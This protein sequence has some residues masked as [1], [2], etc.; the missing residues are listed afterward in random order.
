MHKILNRAKKNAAFSLEKKYCNN[1]RRGNK[2]G[3]RSYKVWLAI[4]T[5]CITVVGVIMMTVIGFELSDGNINV[6]VDGNY[7]QTVS[8][9]KE[10]QQFLSEF[11]FLAI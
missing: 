3:I 5:F 6:F 2:Q 10:L 1:F 11:T 8:N 9:R 7:V 4:L